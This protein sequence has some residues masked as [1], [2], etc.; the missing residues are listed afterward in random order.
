MDIDKR[1]RFARVRVGTW[2][3]GRRWRR[4]ELWQHPDFV[5]LWLAQ[6]VSE[7]GSQLGALPLTA[8]VLL[9]AS[10]MQ[11]GLLAAL[12]AVPVLVVGLQTGVWVDRVRRRPVLIVADLGRM[13]LLVMVLL[14]AVLEWLRIE[15]L[16]IV[17]FLAGVLSVLFTVTHQS[18][19]PAL[20]PRAHLVEGNSKLS[21]SSHLAEIAAPALGGLLVQVGS[22][23]LA[24]LLDACSFLGSAWCVRRIRTRELPLPDSAPRQGMRK[25]VRKGLQMLLGNPWLRLLAG[26]ASIRDFFG[27]FYGAVYGLFVLQ[28]VGLGPTLLGFA[29]GAGGIGALVG[30]LLAGRMMRRW[31]LG[32]TMMGALAI[33]SGVGPV[34]VLAGGPPLLAISLL[35]FAQFTGDLA[36]SLYVISEVSLRQAIT[37]D[38]WMGRI[39]A[40]MQFLVGGAGILGLLVGGALG[41]TTGLRPT[42]AVAALGNIVAY[43]WLRRSPIR[44]LHEHSV[45]GGLNH[46]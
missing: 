25:E 44:T 29:I 2:S 33:M 46:H 16:Y 26:S 14:A 28:T 34:T 6:T 7:V 15:H 12:G 1:I 45:A 24:L 13:L 37:P 42:L 35:I 19:L 32:A 38:Q 36:R 21:I 41:E 8:L 3:D 11:M 43:V 27:G 4:S 10:P 9:G 23:P 20:V 40:S 5:Q 17:A 18:F 30:A 39:T 31:G 22:V